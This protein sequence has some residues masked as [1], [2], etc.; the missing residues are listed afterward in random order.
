LVLNKVGEFFQGH[1]KGFLRDLSGSF[2][3]E[4]LVDIKFFTVL[5]WCFGTD[6]GFEQGSWFLD[7]GFQINPLE[8]NPDVQVIVGWVYGP[9]L[10]FRVIRSP[11]EPNPLELEVRWGE[12]LPGLRFSE[13]LRQWESVTLSVDSTRSIEAIT[14]PFG[15]DV[16]GLWIAYFAS[17][18]G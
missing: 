3:G 13:G 14:I 11:S 8:A 1:A 10:P 12:G 18:K 4:V 16:S 2:P 6:N 5:I 17:S 15:V 9:I 7:T